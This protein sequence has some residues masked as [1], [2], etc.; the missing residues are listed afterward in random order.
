MDC[1]VFFYQT[2]KSHLYISHKNQLC[3]NDEK[4]H[5]NGGFKGFMNKKLGLFIVFIFSCLILSVGAMLFL[6]FDEQKAQATIKDTGA[7]LVDSYDPERSQ[8]IFDSQSTNENGASSISYDA[9]L[10][11]LTNQEIHDASSNLEAIKKQVVGTIQAPSI[12]LNLPIL[13]GF[14]TEKLA[15][16]VGTLK[17]NQ[18]LNKV[19]NFAL[20]GHNMN[21]KNPVLFSRITQ[22][23]GHDVTVQYKGKKQTYT[24]NS[25]KIIKPTNIQSIQDD[26]AIQKNEKMLSLITCTLD[27]QNRYLVQGVA[28]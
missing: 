8:L 22:L 15:V 18:H 1:G 17:P 28:K 4:Y 21:T 13:E 27:G 24:I 7:E 5:L 19:G 20:A 12:E 26:D 14:S 11:N 9:E 10:K 6:Y 25:I 3:Y 2:L 23:K 16:G